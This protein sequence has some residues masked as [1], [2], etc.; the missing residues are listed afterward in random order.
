MRRDTI[1]LLSTAAV[2]PLL[3]ACG[4][5]GGDVT[6]DPAASETTITQRS[7]SGASGTTWP[8]DNYYRGPR[9]FTPENGGDVDD[10]Y[11]VGTFEGYTQVLDGIDG[12]PAPFRVFALTNPSR[13]V[14]DVVDE[15][16]D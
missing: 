2:V 4:S 5:N 1:A 3:A 11:V 9:Q 16:A 8:A 12:A 6:S 15:S 10:V 13:L 14:V 7:T